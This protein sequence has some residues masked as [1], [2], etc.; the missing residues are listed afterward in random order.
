MNHPPVN[1]DSSAWIM[2]TW[3]SFG[4]AVLMGSIGIYY[5]PADN[6][7]RGFLAISFTFAIGT[8]F[9]LAKTIRDNVEADKHINRA[10]DAR[11]EHLL[12]EYE[13]R[14]KNT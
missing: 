14:L 12:N 1:K 9:T 10:V 2:F 4:I 7:V 5:V 6:W 13:M 3:V 8:S 11:T